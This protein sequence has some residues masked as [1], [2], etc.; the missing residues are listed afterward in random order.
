MGKLLLLLL[1]VPIVE[2][3]LLITIGRSIGLLPT[4][5]LLFGAGVIG[6]WLARFEG[7]RVVQAWQRSMAEGRAPDEGVL[8]GGLVLLGG[9][10]FIV[11]GLLTDFFG[12]LLILPP[13]RRLAARAVRRAI[14]RRLRDGRLRVEGTQITFGDAEPRR[15]ARDQVID[16]T[17]E[18]DERRTDEPA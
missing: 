7:M 14:E 15:P 8:S 17:P 12:L 4:L 5:A 18:R 13:T 1:L 10:L 2:I 6:S 11:P 16:V 3:Y 9:L